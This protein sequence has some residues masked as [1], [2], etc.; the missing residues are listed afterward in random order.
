MHIQARLP[1]NV[2]VSIMQ[3]KISPHPC[4]LEEV[5]RIQTVGDCKSFSL[6]RWGCVEID[7]R[8]QTRTELKLA[9]PSIPLVAHQWQVKNT[10]DCAQV[11]SC[12]F[13]DAVT[14]KMPTQ[15]ICA[16]ME[17][18]SRPS[19]M[20]LGCSNLWHQV[21]QWMNSLGFGCFALRSPALTVRATDCFLISFLLKSRSMFLWHHLLSG[22]LSSAGCYHDS[23]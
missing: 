9:A 3:L 12:H 19:E 7:L 17:V 20:R 8:V 1:P 11:V 16:V 13:S 15:H 10:N 4:P 22:Q 23:I 6:Q 21:W 14:W 5:C 2:L 18:Y